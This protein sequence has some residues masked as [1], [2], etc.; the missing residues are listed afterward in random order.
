[1]TAMPAGKASAPLPSGLHYGHLAPLALR[2]L[3]FAQCR[4]VKRAHWTAERRVVANANWRVAKC[5]RHHV[6]PLIQAHS[7]Q[8]QR[9]GK[10]IDAVGQFASATALAQRLLRA[11]ARRGAVLEARLALGAIECDAQARPHAAE[12]D[13]RRQTIAALLAPHGETRAARVQA[14][15]HAPAV[16]FF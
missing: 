4:L 3:L 15:G 14:H 9:A 12:A 8:K 2:L 1:M 13:F 10:T 6:A 11:N 5:G 16:L 7:A